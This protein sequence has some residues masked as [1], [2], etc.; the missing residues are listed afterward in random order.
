MSHV[1]YI[2]IS[3]NFVDIEFEVDLHLRSF[4]KGMVPFIDVDSKKIAG[5]KNLDRSLL[6]G[7]FNYIDVDLFLKTIKALPHCVEGFDYPD[8]DE[9]QIFI[10]NE[11]DSLWKVRTA[12][13]ISRDDFD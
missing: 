11:N 4:T 10:K 5:D 8:M 2:I 12:T 7:A 1:T 13:E 6:I 3:G 9:I